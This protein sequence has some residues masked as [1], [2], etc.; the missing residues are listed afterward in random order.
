MACSGI[1]TQCNK[2]KNVKEDV[3]SDKQSQASYNNPQAY[4]TCQSTNGCRQTKGDIASTVHHARFMP[5]ATF[6]KHFPSPDALTLHTTLHLM[7]SGQ[8]YG[9]GG[10]AEYAQHFEETLTAS[11]NT[12]CL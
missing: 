3:Y 11:E 12:K 1:C 2:H 9:S 6:W 4:S 5:M 8:G 10:Y 7:C